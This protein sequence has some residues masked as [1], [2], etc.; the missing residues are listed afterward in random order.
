MKKSK[1]IVPALA[2]IAFSTAASITGSVA[3]FT[4]NRSVTINAGTY[5]VVKTNAN[6]DCVL[7]D[8]VGATASGDTITIGTNKKLTDASFDH[9]N[10]L[11]TVPD[12]SG[13]KIAATPGL[14]SNTLSADL[15]RSGDIYTAFTWRMTLTVN[16]GAV[17]SDL[18]LY[19]DTAGSVFTVTGQ[20]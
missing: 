4:A 8:G 19:I 5:A 6:L 14:A 7:A 15:V 3:W 1:L 2:V 12:A 10:K 11:F 20:A 9:V 18:G 16:F 17:G 13:K